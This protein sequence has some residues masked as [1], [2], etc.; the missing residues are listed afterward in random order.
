MNFP[1]FLQRIMISEEFKMPASQIDL[2]C[3]HP[4]NCGLH[5]Q[6]KGGVVFLIFLKLSASV[7]DNVEFAGRV[8]L[9]KD[10]PQATLRVLVT[11]GSICNKGILPVCSW[12]RQ[13][14]F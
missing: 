10:G 8:D 9:G 5:L 6:Q 13:Y 1:Q 7:G 4:E 2:K 14:W 12:V 3:L 11:K